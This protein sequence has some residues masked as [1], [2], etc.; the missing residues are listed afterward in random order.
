MDP[1][2]HKLDMVNTEDKNDNDGSKGE[3]DEDEED[4]QNSSL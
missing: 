2:G 1:R 4:M 3:Q